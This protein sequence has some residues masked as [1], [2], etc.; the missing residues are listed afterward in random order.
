[1]RKGAPGGEREQ[2]PE[3][4][5]G[6]RSTAQKAVKTTRGSIW[7]LPQ[8]QMPKWGCGFKARELCKAR[9]RARAHS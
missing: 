5:R 4:G 1:M 7:P 6:L 2:G 9:G 3:E 8:N